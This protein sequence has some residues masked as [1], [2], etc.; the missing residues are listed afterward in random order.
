[1][2]GGRRSALAA[3]AAA[4]MPSGLPEWVKEQ[5]KSDPVRHREYLDWRREYN[6]QCYKLKRAMPRKTPSRRCPRAI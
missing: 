1:M 4:L 2:A 6:R 5:A 3:V